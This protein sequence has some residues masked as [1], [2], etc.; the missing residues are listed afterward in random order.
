M[1]AILLR[2]WGRQ[3]GGSQAVC[4]P[5]GQVSLR[6]LQPILKFQIAMLMLVGTVG[7]IAVV[8]AEGVAIAP[9]AVCTLSL[10]KGSMGLMSTFPSWEQ[11]GLVCHQLEF[12]CVMVQVTYSGLM[13]RALPQVMEVELA[14]PR[15]GSCWLVVA[16]GCRCRGSRW[17][18]GEWRVKQQLSVLGWLFHCGPH[19]CFLLMSPAHRSAS[20]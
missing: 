4:D 2:F 8:F 18:V 16:F 17:N 7:Q 11:T 1:A 13:I 20:G 3:K 5:P 6:L 15:S 14:S 12:V 10:W 9:A 19:L